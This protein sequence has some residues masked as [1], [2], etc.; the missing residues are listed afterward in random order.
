MD[1]P[2]LNARYAETQEVRWLVLTHHDL[3]VLLKAEWGA[4]DDGITRDDMVALATALANGTP[5]PTATPS[6]SLPDLDCAG[7]SSAGGQPK[8]PIGRVAIALTTLRLSESVTCDDMVQVEVSVRVWADTLAPVRPEESQI[9]PTRNEV[10]V[11]FGIRDVLVFAMLDKR[12]FAPGDVLPVAVKEEDAEALSH[13][14]DAGAVIT[15]RKQQSH[16]LPACRGAT[17]QSTQRAV[18]PSSVRCAGYI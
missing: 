3:A 5:T 17:K 10:Y 2:A 7:A 1:L 11:S 9:D 14:I 4:T 18:Q 6:Q 16:G 15:V 13:A 12:T 8:L